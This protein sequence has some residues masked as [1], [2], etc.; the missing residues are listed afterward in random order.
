V[1]I[2]DKRFWC[3]NLDEEAAAR[4]EPGAVPVFAAPAHS[5]LRGQIYNLAAGADLTIPHEK[6]PLHLFLVI[7]ISGSVE[8]EIGQRKLPLGP[9]SQLVILPGVPCRL[10]ASSAAAF[11]LISLRSHRPPGVL[12]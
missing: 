1:F 4:R 11:E 2:S 8:A 6:W 9:H 5:D 3:V 7:G 10:Q 12:G